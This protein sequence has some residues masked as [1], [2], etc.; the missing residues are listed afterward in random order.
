MA[1]QR[2]YVLSIAGFD[3]SGGAGILADIKT[4]EM[5]RV[6]GL[7]VATCMTYQHESRFDG[8]HWFPEDSIAAQLDVLLERYTIAAAKIGLIGTTD[9]LTMAID[10]LRSA[11]PA[12]H[13][14]WDPVMSASAG[15]RFHERIE[16]SA[17]EV[18][19]RSL[20]GHSVITP[21]W[22]EMEELL[23]VP[24]LEGAAK[25]SAWCP[26]LLKGGHNEQAKGYDYLFTQ[27]TMQRF[28]P[29]SVSAYAK[30]GSGC[31]LSAALAAALAQGYKL[32]RACLR[33]KQYTL[34]FLESTPG[35]LG[36]HKR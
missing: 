34:R 35:L 5:H 27:G 23:P 21:N 26:V 9:V 25:M 24:A 8:I 20:G 17:L 29:K 33:A 12:V 18:I 7:G 31:V 4:F 2:P 36:F 30:H 28:R 14:V 19:T 16:S 11:N 15:F 32:H 6:T 1:Q 10:K 22:K 13:I 3:P